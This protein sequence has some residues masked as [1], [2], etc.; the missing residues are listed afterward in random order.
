MPWDKNNP[1]TAFFTFNLNE[2]I[3]SLRNDFNDVIGARK[4]KAIPLFGSNDNDSNKR[5]FVVDVVAIGIDYGNKNPVV[6]SIDPNTLIS[7]SNNGE[8]TRNSIVASGPTWRPSNSQIKGLN[9]TDPT[10]GFNIKESS[11]MKLN[12]RMFKEYGGEARSSKKCDPRDYFTDL[13]Y[14]LS[15]ISK[16]ETSIGQWGALYYLSSVTDYLCARGYRIGNPSNPNDSRNWISVNQDG[17]SS[18]TFFK[19]MY[20]TVEDWVL[21]FCPRKPNDIAPIV[22]GK[23]YE[24]SSYNTIAT[25]MLKYDI[26]GRMYVASV[27]VAQAEIINFGNDQ[28]VWQHMYQSNCLLPGACMY[29]GQ[30]LYSNDLRY[31]AYLNYY[32]QIQLFKLPFSK[33]SISPYNTT[34]KHTSSPDVDCMI[35]FCLTMQTDGNLVTYKT[36]L[37]CMDFGP[38]VWANGQNNSITDS[39]SILV[40]E[41]GGVLVHY[42]QGSRIRNSEVSN[43]LNGVY[44]N[45]NTIK[46]TNHYDPNLNYYWNE[47]DNEGNSRLRIR[48]PNKPNMCLDDG[49]GNKNGETKFHLWEC[50][51]NN[52]NQE[53]VYNAKTKL[54]RNPNKNN[55]CLDDGGG[56]KNGETKFHLW[57][58]DPNNKNQQFDYDSATKLFRNPNKPNMCLDDGGGTKNGETKFH[59]WECDPNNKNQQFDIIEPNQIV[60]LKGNRGYINP[61][62]GYSYK[63]KIIKTGT[64]F[65][66]VIWAFPDIKNV[67]IYYISNNKNPGQYLNKFYESNLTAKELI[68]INF[69]MNSSRWLTYDNCIKLRN[70]S[71]NKLIEDDMNRRICRNPIYTSGGKENVDWKYVTNSNDPQCLDVW[72]YVDANGNIIESNIIKSTTKNDTKPWCALKNETYNIQTEV[73]Q[74]LNPTDIFT[75]QIMQ[76]VP[77]F[78]KLNPNTTTKT[79]KNEAAQTVT[80]I[81]DLIMNN[82]KGKNLTIEELVRLRLLLC[83]SDGT[84]KYTKTIRPWIQEFDKET[85]SQ[86]VLDNMY[87]I[88]DY[89]LTKSIRENKIPA[90][91]IFLKQD[92][93]VRILNYYIDLDKIISNDKDIKNNI[94]D[95][96]KSTFFI[97]LNAIQDYEGNNNSFFIVPGIIND[98][99]NTS[100]EFTNSLSQLNMPKPSFLL[101]AYTST[102]YRINN[103]TGSR[104]YIYKIKSF[105]DYFVNLVLANDTVIKVDPKNSPNHNPFHYEICKLNPDLCISAYKDYLNIPGNFNS[106]EY[107]NICDNYKFSTEN[108][109]DINKICSNTLATNICKDP[110][111]RYNNEKTEVTGRTLDFYQ[112]LWKSVG[113]KTD[114]SQNIA[115]VTINNKNNSIKDLWNDLSLDSVMNN[116][117][118]I[119][120]KTDEAN[121]KLCYG[122]TFANLEAY[123][124]RENFS[125]GSCVDICNTTD[126]SPE[127]KAACDQGTINYCETGDNTFSTIC[128][129]LMGS[130]QKVQDAR[131]KYCQLNPSDTR[132]PQV[133]QPTIPASQPTVPI[134]QPASQPTAPITNDP[135]IAEAKKVSEDSVQNPIAKQV[136]NSGVSSNNEQTQSPDFVQAKETKN[137]LEWWVYLIIGFVIF[138]ILVAGGMYAF[139]RH[140]ENL[141]KQEIENNLDESG[142]NP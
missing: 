8:Q 141:A 50:D 124:D 80:E 109:N 51:N 17:T 88:S 2:N 91:M 119:R 94:I 1:S 33:D 35:P 118:N 125:G 4:P 106:S 47:V 102:S 41:P 110:L 84:R 58:C 73:C 60:S 65:Q 34:G 66:H 76:K 126:I 78:R 61:R 133:S 72:D 101:N 95:N 52:K 74:Y 105:K 104:I 130:N 48:N 16:N 97:K 87:K 45:E 6:L 25:N 135:I 120:T 7:E 36:K 30:S 10:D 9:E 81:G 3:N 29:S 89:N 21:N 27:D 63:N 39:N 15:N 128:N 32:G 93:K 116:M 129:S 108:K 139:K 42:S 86:F 67:E 121:K 100:T 142:D 28:K 70:T 54:L 5:T 62:V 40:L 131:I 11:L 85:T 14:S 24:I 90:Y 103:N 99:D 68:D 111:K 79:Y 107:I 132:C 136:A 82:I 92:N 71:N 75:R 115:G 138:C 20:L 13:E 19:I 134:T 12:E 53:F 26:V 83:N 37:N 49:G 140:R 127:I 77:E 123:S 113:C 22:N 38:A 59:L 122:D 112:N 96:Q 44:E 114:L 57:T 117:N 69:C 31:K 43:V 137:K 46:T 64:A 98:L 56:T 23:E 18:N 55:L